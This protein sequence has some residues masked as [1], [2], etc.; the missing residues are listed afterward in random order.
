MGVAS[1]GPETLLGPAVCT[2]PLRALAALLTHVD[3]VGDARDC[4]L[5]TD[6]V[7]VRVHLHQCV[8][9]HH[10]RSPEH[11]DSHNQVRVA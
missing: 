11:L 4:L 8:C 7:C 5:R 9:V 6:G 10:M 1:G 2:G 3:I